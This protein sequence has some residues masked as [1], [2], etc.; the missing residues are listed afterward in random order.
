MKSRNHFSFI[1][2]PLLLLACNAQPSADLVVGP[3]AY[4][5]PSCWFK[6]GQEFSAFMVLTIDEA[7]GVP[8]FVS[9]RC[10]IKE[11]GKDLGSSLMNSLEVIEIVDSN[12]LLEKRIPN[13]QITDNTRT[14]LAYPSSESEVY[15]IEAVLEEIN[16]P[17]G[18]FHVAN[19]RRLENTGVQFGALLDMNHAQRLQLNRSFTERGEK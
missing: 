16:Q 8:Y 19:I 13:L 14:D 1:A 15:I 11:N 4:K 9:S 7:E 2:T 3:K 18:Q 17:E 5:N 12:R 10:I 6:K